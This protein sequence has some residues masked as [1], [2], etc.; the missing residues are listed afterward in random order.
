MQARLHAL[1]TTN[2]RWLRQALRLL[3]RLDDTSYAEIAPGF[4]PHRAGAHLRHVVEFYECFLD[5]MKSSHIDY[6]ARRRNEAIARSRHTAALAIKSAIHG[7]ES[8]LE[9]R[10]E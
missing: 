4:A 3:E 7:L 9:V 8:R 6:D 1:I 2:I 5:G 10:Q